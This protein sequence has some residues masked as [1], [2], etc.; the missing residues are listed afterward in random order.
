L[1][2]GKAAQGSPFAKKRE[3]WNTWNSFLQRVEKGSSRKGREEKRFAGTQEAGVG[4][5]KVKVRRKELR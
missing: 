5:K 2:Q 1:G 3:G 4:G